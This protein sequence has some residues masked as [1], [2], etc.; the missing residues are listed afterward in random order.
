V[1]MEQMC[2]REERHLLSTVQDSSPSI[3]F[4]SRC[5]SLTVSC[6]S[7]FN[8]Q[9]AIF[10]RDER[11]PYAVMCICGG[12]VPMCRHIRWMQSCHSNHPKPVRG[13]HL[14]NVSYSNL[15]ALHWIEIGLNYTLFV[16]TDK[17]ASFSSILRN[18]VK[19]R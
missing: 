2:R 9:S 5:C 19:L 16:D 12:V 17:I 8:S 15:S 7:A 18:H 11:S 1:V 4:I 10:H 14:G 6:V 13:R 3:P